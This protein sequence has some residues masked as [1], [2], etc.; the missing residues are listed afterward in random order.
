MRIFL[1][2]PSERIEDAYRVFGFL[3]EFGL[4]TWFDK[5]SLVGGQDWDRERSNAQA[6]TDLTILICSPETISRSGVIQREVK[7]ILKRGADQPLGDVFLVPLRTEELSL[8]PELAKWQYIDLFKGDWRIRLA[9]VLRLKGRQLGEATQTIDA[10]IDATPAAEQMSMSIRE[11]TANYELAADF[12]TYAKPTRYWQFI[13]STIISTVYEQYYS[14]V[15]DFR[16]CVGDGPSEW[17][18]GLEEVFRAEDVVSLR[19]H[20]F[21]SRSRSPHPNYGFFTR[22]FGGEDI[23]RLEL[24]TLIDSSAET[25]AY[26]KDVCQRTIRETIGDPSYVFSVVDY[27]WETFQQFSLDSE[28]L[29]INLS[30]CSGLPHVLGAFEVRFPWGDLSDRIQDEFRSTAAARLFGLT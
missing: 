16:I 24:L 22:N 9:Q 27:D 1:S 30:W 18:L 14:H 21:A 20:Y 5:V 3:R 4:N 6:T 15:H 7:D 11:R 23:G 2:Y 8:P 13:N 19:F 12:F 10:F 17:T 28:G 26:M 25:F 29:T